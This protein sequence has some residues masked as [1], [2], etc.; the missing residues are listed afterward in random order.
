MVVNPGHFSATAFTPTSVTFNE[1]TKHTGIDDGH[2]LNDTCQGTRTLMHHTTTIDTCCENVADKCDYN[3]HIAHV[4][5]VTG[6]Q[7]DKRQTHAITAW[8]QHVHGQRHAIRHP[9]G[10][11]TASSPRVLHQRLVMDAGSKPNALGLVSKAVLDIF[12]HRLVSVRRTRDVD[13]ELRPHFRPAF[14][15]NNGASGKAPKG[16]PHF[17]QKPAP[18]GDERRAKK[19]R[20]WVLQAELLPIPYRLAK[21]AWNCYMYV[22][23]QPFEHLNFCDHHCGT[24]KHGMGGTTC[25]SGLCA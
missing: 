9:T 2:F 22:W 14:S 21:A 4:S 1:Y 15:A 3:A 10:V 20:G 23:S 5:N 16:V 13:S 25:F 7:A 24:A 18:N 19:P 6:T 12:P 8:L 17:S 11:H